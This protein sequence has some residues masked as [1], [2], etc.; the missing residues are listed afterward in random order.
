MTRAQWWSEPVAGQGSA[1]S[2]GIRKQLGKP[3]MDPLTVLVR[4]A[5]QNS[6]DAA[7]RPGIEPVHFGMSL[8]RPGADGL[9]DWAD[10]LLPEPS[11]AGRIG[12][13]EILADDDTVLLA[14]SDRGTSGLG[15]PLRA[16]TVSTSPN[17]PRDFVNLIRNIG[18]KRDKE[19]GGGTYGFGKGILF[20]TSRVGAVLI[21]TRCIWQGH[22]QTRLIGACLGNAHSENDRLYTGR[23]W[24]GS[25]IDDIPNPLLDEQ[26]TAV[27]NALRLPG[28]AEHELGTDIVIVGADL[29]LTGSAEADTEERPRTIREA[30]EFI[31]SSM[32]WNLWPL[33]TPTQGSRPRLICSTYVDDEEIPLPDP[34]KNLRLKP[35]VNAFQELEASGGES[36]ELKRPKQVVGRLAHQIY[37]A[38]NQVTWTDAAAPFLG[39][40]HHCVLLRQADLVVGYREGPAIPDEVVQYGAVFRSDAAAESSFADAE[41]PTHDAWVVEELRDPT[42]R[43]IVRAALRGIDASLKSLV[44]G[45]AVLSQ[46][47]KQPPLGGLS[48]RLATLIPTTKGDGA[49]QPSGGAGSSGSNS[50]GGGNLVRILGA[51]RMTHVDQA[52]RIVASL[53][54]EPVNGSVEVT[55]SATVA[56]EGGTESEPPAG[57]QQ[58]RVLE[59]RSEDGAVRHH[60][61]QIV[62]RPDEP[63][64]WTVVVQPAPDAATRLRAKGTLQGADI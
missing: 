30:G 61:S 43:S 24:W 3:R 42:D 64:N 14:I 23:S 26:A 55:V 56:V 22:P 31:A 52:I 18:E 49:G 8:V 16:D 62:V 58:P 41:P 35:F 21:H 45:G 37:M 1:A 36:I 13:D 7:R 32:L 39:S 27:A 40:A 4:E 46:A 63:R 5:A 54:I 38:S 34:Q 20:T 47:G 19:F 25:V 17:E 50:R 60:T 15:G 10:M 33:M 48:N 53:R 28:F 57:A 29:G 6:W 12:L 44:T 9:V 51:P 11:G 59:I 2:D